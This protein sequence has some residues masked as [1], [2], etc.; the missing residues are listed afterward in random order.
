MINIKA[1]ITEKLHL[2]KDNKDNLNHKAPEPY[3]RKDGMFV[4]KTSIRADENFSFKPG[5]KVV[6]V[7]YWSHGYEAGPRGVFEINKVNR[8][9]VTIKD[10]N[11]NDRLGGDN[12]YE[13]LKFDIKG[14]CKTKL[15]KDN[16]YWV[17]Y[18]KALIDEGGDIKELLEKGNTTWGYSFRYKEK[19][20]KEELKKY[21]EEVSA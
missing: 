12:F 21:V 10:V 14:I 20:R 4:R 3:I 1:Y 7:R 6:L 2:N 8:K 5:E 11:G 17:L 16:S 15:A 18:N 9:S 13:G 19:E